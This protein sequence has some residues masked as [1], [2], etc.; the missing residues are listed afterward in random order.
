MATL[1]AMFTLIDGYSSTI[2]KINRKTDEAIIKILEVSKLTDKFNEKLDATEESAKSAS[3][4]LS[5]FLVL[6]ELLDVAQK[7]MEI[8]DDFM[9]TSIRLSTINS[10]LREQAELQDKVFAAANRSRVA[11]TDMASAITKMKLTAGSSF[12]SNDELIAFT[13]LIQKS[14]KLGGASPE[15]QQAGLLQITD[16]MAEGKLQGDG[17]QSI[18]ENA[19]IIAD[20]ISKYT[21]MSNDELMQ[22]AAEGKL[23]ADILKNAMFYMSN[24]ITVKFNA[25]PSTFA[26][27]WNKM[28]NIALKA[29]R[30]IIEEV[31]KFINGDEF[32]N[33]V[34][35]I[36]VGVGLLSMALGA[37]IGF[38][39]D[40][41]PLIESFLIAIGGYLAVSLVPGFIKAGIAGM[42][43]GLKIA[44]GWFIAYMPIILLIAG[45]ALLIYAFIMSGKTIE[46]VFG[47]IGAIIGAAVAIIFNLFL[48]LGEFILSVIQFWVNPFIE[49]SNFLGNIF[50]N[51]VSSII[52]L[53]QGMADNVLGVLEKIASAMD[54]V[55]GTHMAETIASWRVGLKDMADDAVKKYAPD[56]NYQKIFDNLDLS[57]EDF[58]L[59]L[60]G[61]SETAA[62]GE[63]AGRGVYNGIEDKLNDFKNSLTGEGK[64]NKEYDY[65]QYVPEENPIIGQ[66]GSGSDPLTVQGTGK[67]GAVNVNMEDDDLE[68]LRDIA[69]REYINKFSAATLAPNVTI[70]FGDVHQEADADKLAARMQRILQE[71]IAVAAEGVY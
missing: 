51:P 39:G 61:V 24:E 5:K 43:S 62:K 4:G 27:V 55:S 9:N 53:F 40:N 58:G 30:P 63:K 65:S 34:N 71:Q 54:F 52:Y 64:K 3:S 22:M 7:G 50:T 28:K 13:E 29:F 20:A 35:T 67:N 38:I 45:I 8:S 31:S 37:L 36:I 16:A 69:E 18:M 66:A 21:G 56:E 32:S 11:Y 19:P 49:F 41:W 42:I 14:Y 60:L 2:D 6:T 48:T 15:D 25:L 59:E 33:I 47:I 68:Y 46:D 10:G 17:F 12:K 23:T 44:A 1:K 57:M 70:Q 26:D